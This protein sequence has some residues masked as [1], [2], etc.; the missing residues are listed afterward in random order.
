MFV[1]VSINIVF[2]FSVEQFEIGFVF[3]GLM[4]VFMSFDVIFISFVVG[5]INLGRGMQLVVVVVAPIPLKT[6]TIV[7]RNYCFAGMLRCQL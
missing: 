2:G 7:N 4:V 3:D 6:L 5:G 1:A